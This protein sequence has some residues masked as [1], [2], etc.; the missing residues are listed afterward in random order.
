MGN[1]V[2]GGGSKVILQQETGTKYVVPFTSESVNPSAEFINS[3]A[4]VSNRAKG[5]GQKGN[6]AG[7]GNFDFE[8]SHKYLPYYFLGVLGAKDASKPVIY[9]SPDYL[10]DYNVFVEHGSAAS[11][12][13]EARRVKFNSLRVSFASDG[14]MSGTVDFAG[15]KYVNASG[16]LSGTTAF[17]DS[18]NFIFPQ[19]LA[20]INKIITESDPIETTDWD[21]GID[22]IPYL[23]SIEFTIAN[24]L[25]TDLNKLDAS[26]RMAVT[27]GEFAVT[28]TIEIVL[29]DEDT[30]GIGAADI[31]TNWKAIAIKVADSSG[32]TY[33][34]IVLRNIYFTS[35]THD[36]SDRGAITIS[37]D[38]Q[39]VYNASDTAKVLDGTTVTGAQPIVVAYDESSTIT[40]LTVRNTVDDEVPTG[41]IDGS[42]KTFTLAHT[43]IK[44]GS[45][46]IT[47]NS[48]T[49][50]DLGYGVL[51]DGGTINY[52]TGVF[53]LNEAPA[54]GSTVTV[55]YIYFT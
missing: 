22:M 5:I 2:I 42:N 29:D 37:A 46:V 10:F 38:F 47:V 54:G 9:P 43:P 3:N 34:Y 23:N 13:M 24:N 11:L 40:L 15:L 39:C 49:I 19:K 7:D 50:K 27:G 33:H 4:I 36:I 45:V 35:L 28:G 25:S 30:L 51:S 14:V 16:T 52:E 1:F 6:V 53:V 20:A 31:G 17:A 48:T 8:F 41:D 12:R 55:D 26:G 18:A 32:S 21:A 44:E